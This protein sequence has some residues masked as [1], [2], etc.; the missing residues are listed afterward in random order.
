M[1]S[2][3]HRLC[4]TSTKHPGHSPISSLAFKSAGRC[5]PGPDHLTRSRTIGPTWT[6]S[7]SLSQHMRLCRRSLRGPG[8]EKTTHYLDDSQVSPVSTVP[9]YALIHTM[10]NSEVLSA[11]LARNRDQFNDELPPPYATPPDQFSQQLSRI[12]ES[13]VA[14]SVP[15][16]REPSAPSGRRTQQSFIDFSEAST[17]EASIYDGM[18]LP[19]TGQR[20]SRS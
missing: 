3:A 12:L 9:A 20:V 11:V 16:L 7:L 17:S 5:S 6:R 18:S 19:I 1:S 15:Q 2:A 10:T 4:L 14:Y 8:S 13:S